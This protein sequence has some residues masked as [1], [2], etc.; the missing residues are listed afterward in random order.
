MF[1]Q[2]SLTSQTP[3]PLF[4]FFC[5]RMIFGFLERSLAVFM[6]V[7]QTLI[8][9]ICQYS[10]M[11][12]NIAALLLEE[13]KVVLTSMSKG[14]GNDLSGLLACNQLR[15]LSMTPFFAAEMLF[16]A[17]FGRSTGCSLASTSTTSKTVSLACSAFFPGR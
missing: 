2:N 1:N 12:G 7:C 4:F 10:N 16:L 11:L 8:A 3:I 13:L 17:F 15:F 14:S 5:E 9:C 6:K